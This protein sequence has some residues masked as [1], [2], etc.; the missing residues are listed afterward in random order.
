MGPTCEKGGQGGAK[1]LPSTD[2]RT[3]SR[4]EVAFF[5]TWSK[6]AEK[7]RLRLRLTPANAAPA[8][9]AAARAASAS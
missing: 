4:R 6:Q 8:A 2:W 3:S 9:A 5:C 1:R 7:M